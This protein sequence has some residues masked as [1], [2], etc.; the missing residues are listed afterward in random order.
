MEQELTTMDVC[1]M[2]G[3]I[4][5][6]RRYAMHLGK[7][8]RAAMRNYE[9]TD[10]EEVTFLTDVAYALDNLRVIGE[11]QEIIEKTL[12]LMR[13]EAAPTFKGGEENGKNHAN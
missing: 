2:E 4:S 13:E 5:V 9:S 10:F 11:T 6:L 7:H 12:R 8:L 1:Q 3:A